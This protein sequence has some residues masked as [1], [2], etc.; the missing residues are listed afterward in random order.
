MV[1]DLKGAMRLTDRLG[2]DDLRAYEE[3]TMTLVRLPFMIHLF[4]K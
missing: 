4:T 2:F 1:R 3:F